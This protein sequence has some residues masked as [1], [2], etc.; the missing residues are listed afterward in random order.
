[1]KQ[2]GKC[3]HS[4]HSHCIERWA[5]VKGSCF[6]CKEK[7]NVND[8]IVERESKINKSIVKKKEEELIIKK[9]NEIEKQE[10]AELNNNLFGIQSNLNEL[11]GIVGNSFRKVRSKSIENILSKSP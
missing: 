11:K 7:W 9:N 3:G 6:Q 2:T 10:I 1:M 8:I 5:K 4:F